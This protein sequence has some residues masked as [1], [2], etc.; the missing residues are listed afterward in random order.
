MNH[1]NLQAN[2]G[3]EQVMIKHTK[4][5]AHLNSVSLKNL[6]SAMRMIGMLALGTKQPSLYTTSKINLS[7]N[8]VNQFLSKSMNS[9]CLWLI[10]TVNNS[11]ETIEIALNNMHPACITVSCQY[12]FYQEVMFGSQLVHLRLNDYSLLPVND[13]K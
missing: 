10:I 4:K 6:P 12:R 13:L 1:F 9:A 7:P 5:A 2:V 3:P 8:K 11:T